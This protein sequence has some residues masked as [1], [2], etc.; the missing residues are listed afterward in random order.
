MIDERLFDRIAR[1]LDAYEKDMVALQIELTAI[2]AIAPESGG[3]GEM[4]KAVFLRDFLA[5]LGMTDLEM[6]CAPDERVSSGRRPNIIVR[7]PG[8]GASSPEQTWIISHM[9]IVPPGE[10]GLWKYDP[11]H[12]YVQDGYIIGRGVVDNQQ[13]L[14][15]SLYALKACLDEGVQPARAPGLVF[16]SDEETTSRRGLA[17]LLQHPRNPFRKTDLICVPDSGNEEGTLLEIAEK[18]ILWVH[19]RTLGKQ[20]HGSKPYLGI[21]AFLSASHLAVRLYAALHER[22]P[23]S[24]PLFDPPLS[25]FEPTRKDA[26][27]PNINTI[28]GED[29]FYMDCRVLPGYDLTAVKQ[30]IRE[31]ANAI[32]KEFGVTIEISAA[33]EVQAPEATDPQSPIVI[34]LKQAID[35]VYGV[36]AIHQGIGAGTVAAYLR[37]EGY[38]V[39]VWCRTTPT[40]H[41]PNEKCL[42]ADMM[43]NAKV[44]AHLFLQK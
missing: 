29:S 43:G 9:D 8:P 30:V 13:D 11:Y 7:Y 19:F 38:P 20:C 1:R 25:T 18:S 4:K 35:R 23:E 42:I 27:V 6:I 34:F 26:N 31:G 22:F 33:Q 10:A 12:A 41:Q 40:A 32:E 3:D 2:P 5:Q 28:P 36:Q 24:D 17:Y 39:A 37:R 15:A 21:N 44:F 14:V 16:V